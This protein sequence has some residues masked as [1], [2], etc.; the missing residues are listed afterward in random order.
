M[1]PA[2]GNGYSVTFKKV[3]EKST[4]NTG[5]VAKTPQKPALNRDN[6]QKLSTDWGELMKDKSLLKS[7]ST[8]PSLIQ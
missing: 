3:E 2:A 8:L 1:L 6:D 7:E 5:N 4:H